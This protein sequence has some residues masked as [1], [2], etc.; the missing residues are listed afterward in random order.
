MT[1]SSEI[2]RKMTDAET[3]L[4]EMF[5]QKQT[6][7]DAEVFALRMAAF[8]V[9]TDKGLP[10][11]RNEA[12][13][14]TD[15]RGVM[16]DAKPLATPPDADAKDRAK[17][18]GVLGDIGA[19]R[20]VFV[21][22][23][24]APELSD[25]GDI[26]KGL[27][28]RPMSEA[29][30]TS[31]A[32][33]TAHLGKVFPNDDSAFALNTAFMGDGV[34]VHVAQ[35]AEVKRPLQFVFVAADDKASTIFLRSLVVAEKGSRVTLIETFEGADKCG[36]HINAATE[37]VIGDDARVDRVKINREG[38]DSIHISTVLASIGAN[39]RFNDFGLNIGGSL[40][41]NQF[42]VRMAGEGAFAGLQGA[43]LL[44]GRQHADTTLIL[45]HAAPRCESR[46]LFKS[47]LDND[48]RAVF[49]GKIAVQPQAQKT[50]ARMMARALLLSQTAQADCKPELE[51][52]ADDVQCGHGSTVGALDSE[53]KF[54]LMARGIPDKEAE[55]L[56]IE[57]FIGET[58]DALENDAVRESARQIVEAWMLGRR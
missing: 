22:G 30:A 9:F 48:A 36:Y 25:L 43:N 29:L 1:K 20:I 14:Y 31:D 53:L 5:A 27:S 58:L 50:D 11:R 23:F 26:E 37:I 34:V 32:L 56:L 49:Q 42:F 13:K 28:I 19:R 57:A 8:G 47:V 21:G 3:M 39:A 52:F 35:G 4:T 45:D 33:I 24:F 54:Y 17:Q 10:S 44:C 41:R 16:R 51:I 12:W 46:E 40:V 18:A 7:G 55:A 6:S 38:S 15:L 2:Q